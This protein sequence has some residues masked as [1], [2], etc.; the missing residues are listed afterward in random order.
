MLTEAKG[1]AGGAAA[2]GVV[3]T[4]AGG[5]A[6]AGPSGAQPPPM[7]LPV[8]DV[9]AGYVPPTH[10]A[11]GAVHLPPGEGQTQPGYLHQGAT[12]TTAAAAGAHSL[13]PDPTPQLQALAAPTADA[14]LGPKSDTGALTEDQAAMVTSWWNVF[15]DVSMGMRDASM[16]MR[17]SGLAPPG[18]DGLPLPVGER[19]RASKV[20]VSCTYMA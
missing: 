11:A 5:D 4:S 6:G 8:F 1:G 3:T 18:T 19:G 16:G 13:H 17:A 14:S 7:V 15:A 20:W 2:G 12:V 9:T 10:L